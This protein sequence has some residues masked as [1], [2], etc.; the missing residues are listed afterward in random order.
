MVPKDW[1]Q[2][3]LES[4]CHAPITYGVLKP[5]EYCTNGTPLLQIKDLLGNLD[6]QENI[7][8]I[9]DELDFEYRR[10]KIQVNDILISLVGTVGRIAIVPASL[11]GANI[12]R[13]IGRIRTKNYEFLVHY[14]NSDVAKNRI[15]LSSSGS[16]Q[17][18]LNL[19]VLRALKVP[20]PP[21]PEQRKIAK[22]LSTWDKA[23]ATTEQL[24]AASQQ[25]K[26]ALMQQLLTG[27]KRLINPETGKVFE[28][29]WEEVKLNKCVKFLNG[30][31]KPIKQED[32]ANIQGK[33]PY[34]GATGIIDYVNDYIFDDEI[35][36]LGEDGENILS[37]VLPHVF[38]VRGKVWVNNHAHVLKAN[39]NMDTNFLCMYLESLDYKRYNSGSAQPKIN[40]AVCEKIPVVVPVLAEQ[41]KI[42]SVL[43]AAD[44]EI[45]LL[46]AKLAH[47]KEEKKALMQQLLTGKRRVKVETTEAA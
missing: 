34:Y 41:Q 9:S 29:S 19:S 42:A 5:G 37:R 28:G 45:E 46:E 10:S 30:Q 24:I 4:L 27:K 22:I 44:K 39:A 8:R 21:L 23:I 16:S 17:S 20:V 11:D 32:R 25:Q 6:N 14:L 38:V 47:L 35:I 7:H 36:L 12:H 26:K 43:T 2:A 15:G 33:Y 18:A 3:T 1:N 13:N 40:K 31:R